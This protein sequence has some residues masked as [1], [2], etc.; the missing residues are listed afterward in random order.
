[1]KKLLLIA[2]FL[3]CSCS[4]DMPDSEQTQAEQITTT[5][6]SSQKTTAPTQTTPNYTTTTTAAETTRA[7]IPPPE[8]ILPED[9]TYNYVIPVRTRE[10]QALADV[11]YATVTYDIYG[12]KLRENTLRLGHD[13]RYRDVYSKEYFE[14][15][16]GDGDL[17]MYTYISVWLSAS[18]ADWYYRELWY[19]DGETASLVNAS[20]GR[21]DFSGMLTPEGGLPIVYTIDNVVMGAIRQYSHVYVVRDGKPDEYVLPDPDAYFGYPGSKTNVLYIGYYDDRE[22]DKLIIDSETRGG[23]QTLGWVD[24]EIVV[25]D[26]YGAE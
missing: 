26:G 16:D 17:E 24:G 1:L 11:M 9:L 12:E 10:E 20:E 8:E 21:S 2:L 3:L 25:I 6:F 18:T 5:T 14:D 23:L 22:F 13:D 4:A 15:F 7:P 19:T